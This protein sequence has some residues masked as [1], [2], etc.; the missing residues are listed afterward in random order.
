MRF[1]FLSL[2]LHAGVATS[3][4]FFTKEILYFDLLSPIGVENKEN[5]YR[6]NLNDPVPPK[7]VSRPLE[8]SGAEKKDL[9]HTPEAKNAHRGEV[10][11]QEE[12]YAFSEVGNK[13]E[14]PFPSAQIKLYQ[15]AVFELIQTQVQ[16]PRWARM[17]GLEGELTIRITLLSDG[18]LQAINLIQSS[19]HP[20]LDRFALEQVQSI[21]SFPSFPK[22]SQNLSRVNFAIPLHFYTQLLR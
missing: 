9:P 7:G 10:I 6:I 3:L 2:L 18:A 8:P 22:N 4:F 15:K 11:S 20:E 17:R 13:T 16:Y 1:L 19:G 12:P 14:R 5:L 21:Q